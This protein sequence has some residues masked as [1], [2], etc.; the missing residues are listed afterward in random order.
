MTDNDL[1]PSPMRIDL[2]NFQEVE[3]DEA[4]DYAPHRRKRKKKNN[5]VKILIAVILTLLVVGVIGYL[6]LKFF[7]GP[8]VKTV[9]GLPGDFPDGL[10]LYQVDKAQINLENQAGKEKMIAGL[11]SMPDWVLTLFLNSLSNDLKKKL[12]DNF[13]DDI[14]IN[15]N[16]S[17]D[18]LKTA[19]REVDLN[20]TNTVNL[21]WNGLD[22]TKE[23]LAAY[24]KEK[25]QESN[26]QFKESLGDY[27]IN[28]GFWK[29]DV[30]GIM[31]FSDKKEDIEGGVQYNSNVDMTVNYLNELKK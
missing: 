8:I 25:L 4:F 27:Q 7:I 22:K 18:D 3:R 14:N 2:E 20:K 1:I 10:S 24:Y 12:A 17:V 16:F 6:T 15:K 5:L 29:D 26:F 19:L 30:F 13:G 31:S 11:K 21:S 28:L 23:E 9:D